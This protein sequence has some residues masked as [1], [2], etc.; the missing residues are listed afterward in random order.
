MITIENKFLK[1]LA[2]VI[3]WVC[4][5]L[6]AIITFTCLLQVFARFVLHKNYTWVEEMATWALV[7]TTFL[8][9]TLGVIN[10]AHPRIDALL[11]VMKHKLRCIFEA[12]DCLVCAGIVVTLA[13]YTLPLIQKTKASLSVGMKIPQAILYYSLLIGGALM[14]IFFIVLAIKHIMNMGKEPVKEEAK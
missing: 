1:G 14:A 12:F 4:V 3:K 2:L 6:L 9:S 7:W 10:G 11:L 13:Y 8:G 5:I